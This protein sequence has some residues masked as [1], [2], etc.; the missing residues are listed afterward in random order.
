[1]APLRVD[2]H[3]ED[4]KQSVLFGRQSRHFA[5]FR[6]AQNLS[7]VYAAHKESLI[8]WIIRQT[9]GNEALFMDR[10]RCCAL[11]NRRSVLL[12]PLEN[13]FELGRLFNRVKIGILFRA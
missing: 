9:F 2:F 4:A 6:Y 8:D 13:S 1:M 11:H 12:K 7:L 5:V 3:T 10:E